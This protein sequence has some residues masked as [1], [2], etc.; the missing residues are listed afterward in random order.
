MVWPSRSGQGQAR[1]GLSSAVASAGA[2]DKV[3]GEPAPRRARA[4]AELTPAAGAVPPSPVLGVV[5]PLPPVWGVV[6]PVLGVVPPVLGVVP[7]VL[8][9][10]LPVL[11]VVPPAAAVPPPFAAAGELAAPGLTVVEVGARGSTVPVTLA[12]LISTIPSSHVLDLHG[13]TGGNVSSIDADGTITIWI[14]LVLDI[15]GRIQL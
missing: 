1:A 3:V 10:V 9:V 5:L 7:P 11:G 13:S 14:T 6:P 2:L 8:G 4:C 15:A 12:H